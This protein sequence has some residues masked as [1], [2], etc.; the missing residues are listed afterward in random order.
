MSPKDMMPEDAAIGNKDVSNKDLMP[1]AGKV[2]LGKL[3]HH[4]SP[5][6][7]SPVSLIQANS[8]YM[9]QLYQIQIPPNL[10]VRA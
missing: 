9:S 4:V 3:R 1:N 7:S 5:A 10:G 2:E 8:G 6:S